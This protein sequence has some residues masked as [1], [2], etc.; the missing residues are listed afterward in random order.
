MPR[1]G[2]ESALPIIEPAQPTTI[3]RK[4]PIDASRFITMLASQPAMPPTKN[5]MIQPMCL[6]QRTFG[7]MTRWNR[8]VRG[9]EQR[10]DVPEAMIHV[11]LGSLMLRRIVN[12]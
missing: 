3:L 11:A 2:P 5:A 12:P 6:V 10:I 4:G 8:L 7:R 9:D 1:N